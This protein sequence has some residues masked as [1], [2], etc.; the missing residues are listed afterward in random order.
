MG[1]A[2]C[3]APGR[4]PTS[5]EA[6]A[7]SG[8]VVLTVPAWSAPSLSS[9]AS[10]GACRPPALPLIPSSEQWPHIKPH[11]AWGRWGLGRWGL[12]CWFRPPPQVNRPGGG[13]SHAGSGWREA[14][15]TG[16]QRLPGDGCADWAELIRTGLVPRKE[17]SAGHHGGGH[18]LPAFSRPTQPSRP[19]PARVFPA[20]A[21]RAPRSFPL[22]VGLRRV[23]GFP[24]GAGPASH[25]G[26]GPPGPGTGSSALPRQPAGVGA[27][28]F[29]RVPDGDSASVFS[30][31]ASA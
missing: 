22:R 2:N 30:S 7:R 23:D 9:M 15:V 21:V 16:T 13:A 18:E 31:E 28:S 3:R 6:A 25:P 26:V 11:A 14:R 27:G 4:A 29:T 1:A 12:G 24:S 20:P 10:A 17:R 5:R 19:W 8:A